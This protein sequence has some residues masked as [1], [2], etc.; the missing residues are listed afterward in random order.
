[1][2]ISD[3]IGKLEIV[4]LLTT[5]LLAALCVKKTKE[6]RG[7]LWFLLVVYRF[8]SSRKSSSP[9]TTM[10]MIM[11]MPKPIMYVSVIGAGDGVGGGVAAGAESTVM[12]VSADEP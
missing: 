9:T 4:M 10:A 3:V 5:C 8:L 1:L 7:V 6:K 2:P 12:A 11:P